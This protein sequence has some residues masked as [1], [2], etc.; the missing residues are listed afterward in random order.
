M[1]TPFSE[2][3]YFIFLTPFSL[4]WQVEE[5]ERNGVCLNPSKKNELE[6]L[7]KQIEELSFQYIQN[8]KMDNSF[9]L[10]SEAELAGMPLQFIEVSYCDF[11]LWN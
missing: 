9:L 5:F 11:F 3:V 7:G 8:L 6:S 10:L 4:P 1:S 2:F